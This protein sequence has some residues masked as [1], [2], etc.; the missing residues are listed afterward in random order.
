MVNNVFTDSNFKEQ[1]LQSGQPVVVDFWAP[2]CGPCRL[3]SPIIDELAE[4]YQGQVKVGKLNVD[5]NPQTAS[6]YSIMGIPTVMII[7]NGKTVRTMVGV[8]DKNSYKKEI[9]SLLKKKEGEKI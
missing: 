7:A 9:D 5:E 1:V 3:V 8:R 4:E 2:W 6:S